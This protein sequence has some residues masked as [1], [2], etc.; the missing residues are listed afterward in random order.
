MKFVL[1]SWGSRGE[2]EPCAA[3][4]RELVRRG[5]EV[6]M[7]V[8]PDLVGY[9]SAAVPDTVGF[10]ADLQAMMDAYRD[11]WTGVFHKP[12]R[13]REMNT[14]LQEMWRPLN[15]SWLDMSRTLTSLTT[16]A[17]LLLSSNV[18]FEVQAAD[19]AEYQQIPLATLHWY[20]MRPNGQLAPFLPAPVGRSAMA[21]YDWLSRGGWARK[22]ETQQRRELG[23]PKARGPWPQ[24]VVDRGPLEIQ[25]YDEV[26]FPGLAAEWS[27]WTT[28]RPFV[29]ALTLELQTDADE[30]VASWIEAGTPPIFFGFGSMPVESPAETL[31][32]IA[33]AC[34]RLGQRALVCAG[35]DDFG[36]L[37]LSDHVKVVGVVNF[38]EVFPRCRAV[39]HHGGSGTTALGLR[40]GV[41]TLILST[42][43][44]QALWGAQV[45][46]LKVGAGRR[47]SA[48]NEDT[49]VADLQTILQ[50][51]YR[52]RVRELAARM[53]K[54]AEGAAR[55]ATLV[56]DFARSKT[57]PAR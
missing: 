10:G 30:E 31:A 41:P 33:S 22:V 51:H 7:A 43:A 1:A 27:Q 28:Q 3:V 12:W 17:D 5:H 6:R 16:D 15:S 55:A 19:V 32:M 18:G 26:C 24:R 2:V 25:A 11:F 36:D 29:G 38:A 57:V 40:A 21:A 47:F 23:L 45:K 46:R 53:T 44:N 50:P 9:A 35:W 52:V 39:V 49:L 14:L 13:V 56:E 54:P 20:P 42:D 8:P 37:A 34:R 48:T 4:G